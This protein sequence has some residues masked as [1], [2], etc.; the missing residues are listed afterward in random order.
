LVSIFGLGSV[1]ALPSKVR[2]ALR[3]MPEMLGDEFGKV[4]LGLGGVVL[5]VMAFQ[6]ALALRDAFFPAALLVT[7]DG[8]SYRGRRLAFDDIE[9]VLGGVPIEI[10]GDRRKLRLSAS[11]CPP[12]A[13]A[14]VVAEIQRLIVA[15]APTAPRRV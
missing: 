7:P 11:F 5:V 3:E 15:V 9:E 10:L 2:S 6:I 12:E 1:V 8:V 14:A 13:S 4:L